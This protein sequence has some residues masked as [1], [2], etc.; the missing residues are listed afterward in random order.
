MGPAV[1]TVGRVL[2]HEALAVLATDLCDLLLRHLHLLRHA[3]SRHGL[4]I[5]WIH[6][7]PICGIG[8]VSLV[9]AG[10]TISLLDG[11]ASGNVSGHLLR[12]TSS[13]NERYLCA[14]CEMGT[15]FDL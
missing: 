13:W 12:H 7:L 8:I 9:V 14:T 6:R 15:A 4:A 11:I 1:G 10:R 3:V 2:I 5:A